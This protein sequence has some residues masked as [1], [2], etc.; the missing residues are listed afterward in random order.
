MRRP[1]AFEPVRMRRI[2]VVAPADALRAA[3]VRV[4]DAGAV[5]L[6]DDRGGEAPQDA[7]HPRPDGGEVSPA[8]APDAPDPDDLAR[9]GRL[10][11]L[12]GEAALASV[13]RRATRRGGVAALAGWSPA[14]ATGGLAA[15]LAEVGAAVVPLP[16][17]R[18]VDPPTLL[19]AGGG[20]RRSFAP[21]VGIYGAV[22]YLDV[23]PTL[24]AGL[25]YVLM[26]GMMFADAG[27][28]ALLL[29]AA[30]FLRA[31]RP[32]RLAGLRASWPF[33]AGA[34]L[35]A[36]AFGV[37]FGEFFG[38]TG[39]LPVVWISPLDDPT[40]LLEA[41]VTVGGV[42]LAGAYAVAIL[43]RWRE[44]GPQ[45]ALYA[46]GGVAGALLFLGMGGLA[47]G[48]ALGSTPVLLSAAALVPVGL[49][50]SAVGYYVAGGGGAA[51]ATQAV[52]EAVDAVVR[53]G[54]NLASFARLAAFGLTHAALGW[55][56]WQATVTLGRSGLVGLVA[57]ALLFV[58]G[59]ALTFTL[60]GVVAAIQALRLE[61]YELFSRVF[62]GE[63]RPFR[64][65]HVPTA[66][67]P[68]HPS[69]APPEVSS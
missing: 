23:D 62:A 1:E 42:L 13:A 51:G 57:A 14:T 43:N 30:L 20:V 67:G 65:W 21:V 24:A 18:G 12:A 5:E 27:H 32:R 44:G 36:A 47:A 64:P 4:A 59:N 29:V 33:L 16:T 45:R 8:L 54:S 53:T 41:G 28:G 37:L 69:P 26:F 40:R 66:T 10:D 39:V 49:A 9:R 52:V 46:A 31:G 34:G 48:L 15:A 25:A 11:L 38:P 3:L 55:V 17:P 19:P 7:G 58:V 22:P 50:L 35:A 6:D 2:A 56:V 60:E 68:E 61:F 63:G